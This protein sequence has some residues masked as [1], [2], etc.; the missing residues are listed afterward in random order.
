M[1][2][3]AKA[4]NVVNYGQGISAIDS[5]FSRPNLAAVFCLVRDGRAALID[6]AATV[7][8]PTLLAA[9]AELGIASTAVDWIL[10]THIHLDH[11][12]AAGALM[13]LLPNA[14]LAV[15]KRG[16]RHM[17]DPSR[18]VAGTIAVYGE[19]ETREKYGEILPIAAER[20]V[21]VGEGSVLT[22]GAQAIHVLDTPG[23]APHHVCYVDE[24]TGQIFTGDAFGLSY[25]ELDRDGRAFVLPETSPPQFDPVAMHASVARLAAMNPEAIYVTH[26]GQ[27]RDIPRLAVDLHRLIDDF[28]A[29]ALAVEAAGAGG[30]EANSR[31]EA[32]CAALA[33]L[34]DKEA[35]QQDWG[36]QGEAMRQFLAMDIEVDAQGLDAWLEQR[37]SQ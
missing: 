25:R 37:N 24:L 31:Q 19:T 20:I 26:F 6:T 10:L 27:L 15:H 9:L 36:Q 22:L 23:H 2:N 13:H 33:E 35:R 1:P 16:V 34:F 21:E 8:V 14:R 11:A 12:G 7:N 17:A 3:T 32:L 30:G 29:V 4:S 28:V 18:L 5:G